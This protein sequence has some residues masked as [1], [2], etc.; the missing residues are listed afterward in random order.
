MAVASGSAEKKRTLQF[1]SSFPFHS[2]LLTHLFV[3]PEEQKGVVGGGNLES[4]FS[5]NIHEGRTR[6]IFDTKH[7]WVSAGFSRLGS[8]SS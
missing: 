4:F 1:S 6:L 7:L 8:P 3:F 5:E 2:N